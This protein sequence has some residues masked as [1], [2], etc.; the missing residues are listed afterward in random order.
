LIKSTEC[1]RTIST[2]AFMDQLLEQMRESRARDYSPRSRTSR[3]YQLERRIE[4]LVLASQIT[5]LEDR[6]GYMKSGNAVV[7]LSFPYVKVPKAQ[8]VL[9]ERVTEALPEEPPRTATAAAG[10][11][12]SSKPNRTR[13]EPTATEQ[14]PGQEQSL[15]HAVTPRKKRFFE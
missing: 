12:G 7:Q 15:E 11:N 1:P 4:P 9:I 13:Q 6:R 8:P 2:R 3:N 10:A 5:G 14:K